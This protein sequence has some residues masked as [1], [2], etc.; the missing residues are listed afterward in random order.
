MRATYFPQ[1]ATTSAIMTVVQPPP[2]PPPNRTLVHSSLN[3][4]RVPHAY[5][6]FPPPLSQDCKIPKRLNPLRP[7]PPQ[8]RTVVL[9]TEDPNWANEQ[10]RDLMQKRDHHR[11]HK[12]W[13]RYYY[14]NSTEQELYRKFLRET[15][16]HQM[17][18]HEENRSQHL[19]NKVKESEMAVR[20]DRNDVNNDIET[21][22]V[23]F[24]EMTQYRDANKEMMDNTIERRRQDRHRTNQ[25]D[26]DQLRYNP[27][28]W[29]ASLK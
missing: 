15:L 28:N 11:Y 26:R 10:R 7:P 24:S 12:A 1:L 16:K 9:E 21:A 27:I 6:T 4:V 29:S 25:F 2:S 20:K 5:D 3:N 8:R 23:K 17:H 19:K 18:E 14:G 22:K 13:S